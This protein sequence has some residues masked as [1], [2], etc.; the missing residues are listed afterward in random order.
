MEQRLEW[1]MLASKRSLSLEDLA[2]RAGVCRKTLYNWRRR[3]GSEGREGLIDLPT[4]PLV[5]PERTSEEMESLVVSV[6]ERNPRWGARKIRSY[7]EKAGE[8]DL[9]AASTVHRILARRGLVDAEG[10][11]KTWKRFEMEAP[12]LLWQMDFKGHIPTRNGKRCH[13][14]TVLDDHSRFALALDACGDEKGETVKGRLTETFRRYGVPDSIITDNGSPWGAPTSPDSFTQLAIWLIRNGVRIRKTGPYH[15]QTNG[16]VERFHR[17]LK[18]EVLQARDFADLDECREA[19]EQWRHVYNFQR[20][21]QAL[22]MKTPSELY[23]IS[24]ITFQE[25][26][27]EIVYGPDDEVRKVQ[28]GGWIDFRGFKFRVGKALKGL[29]VAVRPTVEDGVFEVHCVRQYLLQLNLRD[30]PPGGHPGDDDSSL[31]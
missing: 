25:R 30:A 3:F 29:P 22:G 13:P 12:N 28:H 31:P 26:P 27:P 7:L 21:H 10:V 20:P 2:G 14:M 11:A 9:P 4:T 8:G 1:V 16:K 6:R 24:P 19:F 18:A 17:T 23:E 15:P 5:S